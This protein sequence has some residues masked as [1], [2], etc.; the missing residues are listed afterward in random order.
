M[1]NLRERNRLLDCFGCLAFLMMAM[2]FLP[3]V[4]GE[5]SYD[6]GRETHCDNGE[7]YTILYSSARF[8][9]EDGIWKSIDK[10]NVFYGNGFIAFYSEDDK[11]NGLKV[12]G[13]NGSCITVQ[14]YSQDV[15]KFNY[16]SNIPVKVDGS[17]VG[18]ARIPGIASPLMNVNLCFDSLSGHEISFGEHSTTIQIKDAT[19]G[20][21]GDTYAS[22]ANPAVNYGTATSTSTGTYTSSNEYKSGIRF[23]ISGV[24]S[25][26]TIENSALC[27]YLSQQTLDAGEYFDTYQL[28]NQTWLET[29]ITWNYPFTPIG[30]LVNSTTPPAV[31]NWMCLNVT[32]WVSNQYSLSYSNCSFFFNCSGCDASTDDRVSWRTRDYS[33]DTT[34]R[35]Y[36][37]ITYSVIDNP[38]NISWNTPT[39]NLT[40]TSANYVYW[41]ASVSET[42][43][44][45]L[46]NLNVSSNTSMSID[47]LYCYYNSTG[48]SNATYVGRVYANDTA[49]NM[50]LS[51]QQWITVA[52][53]PPTGPA[54]CYII[55][56]GYCAAGPECSPVDV[57]DFLGKC[58]T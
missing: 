21:L 7:C 50:N 2:L 4:L 29:Q 47:G 5:T 35:P 40:T 42:P 30:S 55:S 11:V 6:Y 28:N 44:A 45:C 36:L 41:N 1:E 56:D 10:A 32:S 57:N 43:S 37:N 39:P 17:I 9:P 51:S 14:P 33:A 15:L 27:L 22:R 26:A 12:V 31:S 19:T 52:Y 20:N 49:G 18:Y 3:S 13:F 54:T 24:P 38:P 46:F 34:M 8:V 58:F 16:N 53:S 23:N 48:L 25:S